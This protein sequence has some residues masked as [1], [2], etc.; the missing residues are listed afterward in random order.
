MSNIRLDIGGEKGNAWYI[1]STAYRLCEMEGRDRDETK[2][3]V[4]RMRGDIMGALGGKWSYNELL[5]VFLDEFPYV[6]LYADRKIE[7]IE[8][9]LY[10]VYENPEIRE[11]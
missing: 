5:R 2:E 10:T 7:S 1:M 11:L 3:I 6:E 8:D 4:N 9:D